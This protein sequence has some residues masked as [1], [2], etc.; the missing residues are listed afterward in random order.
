M[1]EHLPD[2]AAVLVEMGRA[3]RPG[4]VG[5]VSAH[6]WTSE[7]GAHDIRV[8][9]GDREE[10]SLWAHLRPAHRHEITENTYLNYWSVEQYRQLSSGV[11]PKVTSRWSST[12]RIAWPC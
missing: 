1:F 6:Y 4:G 5:F 8:F 3:L 11:F 9:A 12:N 7:S 2:P 10:V